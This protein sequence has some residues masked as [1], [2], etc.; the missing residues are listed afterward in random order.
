MEKTQKLMDLDVEFHCCPVKKTE[1][2]GNAC[3]N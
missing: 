1:I 3:P 2:A